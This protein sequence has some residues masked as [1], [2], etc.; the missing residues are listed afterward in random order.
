MVKSFYSQITALFL[1]LLPPYIRDGGK[2]AIYNWLTGT[3]YRRAD[4]SY[5]T[6]IKFSDLI[7]SVYNE[8]F[9]IGS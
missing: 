3:N 4:Q 6:G 9:S 5:Y 2:E 7:Y 8:V 1:S